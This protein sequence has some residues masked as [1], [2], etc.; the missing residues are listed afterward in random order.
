MKNSAIYLMALASVLVL[1]LVDV[2]ARGLGAGG[3]DRGGAGGGGRG[4][5][6]GHIGT[7][8]PAPSRPPVHV[9]AP[10]RSQQLSRP[11]QA[12]RQAPQQQRVK[13]QRSQEKS[14]PSQAQ[15]QASQQ[16]R[17]KQ[18][19][20]QEKSRPSQAQRQAS[21]Q[22]R[23][24]QQRSQEKSRPSQA[25]RQAS[26]QQLVKQQRSQEK[27]RPAQAQRQA[28]QQQ[29]VK[30]Q[31]SQEKSR[32]SQAQRQASQQ[33]RVKQQ[34]SHQR[35]QKVSRPAQGEVQHFLNLP[36]ASQG[37]RKPGLGTIGAAAGGAAAA[38]AQQRL[39]KPGGGEAQRAGV[40]PALMD[41][42][43]IG[44]NRRGDH[45]RVAQQIRNNYR[46]QNM[47]D[48]GWWAN[49]PHLANAS[50]HNKVWRHRSWNYW[51]RPAT[52]AIAAAWFPWG[53]SSPV[54]YDFGDNI[55]YDND[56]VY[57]NGERVATSDEYYQQAT[58]L[59]STA[60][61]DPPDKT[62]WLPLGVFALSRGDTGV[63]NT[64]LQLAVSKEGM[65][66]GT[67]YNSDTDIARPVK[68][69]VDKKTQRAAWTFADGKDANIVMETGINNLTQDQTELLV[70]FGKDITQ[71][72]LMVRLQEP[73]EKET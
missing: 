6:R 39:S 25:Q 15:R 38:L 16:Q 46:G 3:G 13:Q 12:Q 66:S 41:R 1:S 35:S 19:R 31:R 56:I 50:W 44:H 32:P 29:R 23:V 65:I 45:A 37:A 53:W 36:K 26:Q 34:R 71:Q 52:W 43:G 60:K 67:Y 49:H 62:E 18:Q 4:G 2:E 21:Q 61:E 24:K 28:P 73:S 64:V 57:M 27:S 5:Q 48:S 68:G 63:S 33:Q 70:H 17:V 11:S 51:W 72:W 10:Q 22:Q 59:A 47:L 14:R 20:S 69:S 55:L 8:A 9:R 40:D 58:R 7:S 30:Q 42:S 54:S